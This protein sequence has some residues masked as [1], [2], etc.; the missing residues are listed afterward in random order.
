[1]SCAKVAPVAAPGT[2]VDPVLALTI[3]SV[4]DTYRIEGLPEAGI[5]GF[6]RLRT[7]RQLHEAEGPVLL[8]HGGD[9]LY[10]SP[11]SQLY[12]GRQVVDL[13]NLL[14]GQEGV[15]DPLFFATLGN[16][17]FDKDDAEDAAGL[18]ETLAGAEL[19]WVSSNIGWAAG[20]G[21]GSVVDRSA[22]VEVGDVTVGL[23]GITGPFKHP[24]YVD[25]FAD[26]VE[27]ARAVT[28]ELRD[29]GA[30]LVVGLTHLDASDDVAL[31]DTLG[32]EGPDLVVGGHDHAAMTVIGG[33][34]RWVVKADADAASA[35]VTRVWRE[36]ERW[37]IVPD[38]V[39]LD[40]GMVEDPLV[41]ARVDE[42]LARYGAE[43]CAL[44][45]QE[46]G[47]L[48]V[49]LGCTRTG[50]V[51]EEIAIRAR[52]TSMGSW[53]ADLALGAFS[54]QGGQVALINAGG[55]RLNKDLPAGTVLTQ[56]HLDELLPYSMQTR[57]LRLTGSQLQA[58]VEHG[59]A[60]WPGSGRFLQV[61]GLAVRHDVNDNS[62]GP[63]HLMTADG[64]QPVAAEDEVL[65][66]TVGYLADGGDGY[67]MLAAG[68][69]VDAAGPELRVLITDALD[70]AG[71]GCVAPAATGRICQERGAAF[72]GG[73][74][75]VLPDCLLD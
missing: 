66:V 36:G 74:E 7:L 27:T 75:P 4:N 45:G 69:V 68:E 33:G 53:V 72:I 54:G 57:L 8:L 64:P 55:L 16:H 20:S 22:L 65:V 19:G 9:L 2:E 71:E 50:L 37:R 70:A 43:R 39:A 41:A 44:L 62:V 52:E 21:L 5:G 18:A 28:A 40:G 34:A 13:L 67:D 63:V 23:L 17:E 35:V 48:D 29:A 6:A 59:V 1:M 10:P 25:R 14:D 56:A 32:D 11:M 15:D 24:A 38:V 47:C 3:I 60:D 46:A 58:A 26:P 42:W 30:E 61:A 31:L 73:E 49:P 12:G 51:A